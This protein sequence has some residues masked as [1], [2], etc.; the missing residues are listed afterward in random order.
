MALIDIKYVTKTITKLLLKS[1]E[2]S[3]A[4]GP[5][6]M[7][8]LS[9]T[10]NSP[11]RLED[12]KSN[13]VSFYLYHIT[14]NV[15]YKN[16]PIQALSNSPNKLAPM[17]LNLYYQ[18]TATYTGDQDDNAAALQ[19]QSMMSIALK[20]LHDYPEISDTTAVGGTTIMEN[21]VLG[22]NNRFKITLLPITHTEALNFWNAGDSAIRLS[23]YYEVSVV[24]LEP[25][26]IQSRAARVLSYGVHTFTVGVPRLTTSFNIIS[27]NEPIS[28]Q[29]RSLKSK[30]AQ[31]AI[32]EKVT[33]VGSDLIGDNI[34]VLLIN[35]NWTEPLLLSGAVVSGQT[36][37]V[38]IPKEIVVGVTTTKIIPGIY[39]VKLK[40]ERLASNGVGKTIHVSNQSPFTITPQIKY[41]IPDANVGG[42]YT[43]EGDI[44]HYDDG[45][46]IPLEVYV[47]ANKLTKVSPA[48]NNDGEFSIISATSLQFKAPDDLDSGNIPFRLIING[49]ESPPRWIKIP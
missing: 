21:P 32:G 6:I 5:S 36:L 31:V 37:E 10:S 45:S 25:E 27:F 2:E 19:E 30:P 9:I 12:S 1:F 20:A 23:A 15:Q 46:D 44:F 13:V 8:T 18:L 7:N 33:F 34:E 47:G 22:E 4:W 26:P 49:A 43:V 11:H 16:L 41:P 48:P 14:E 24:L 28:E 29:A 3:S 40:V 39:A 17:G 35:P 38:T 42:V